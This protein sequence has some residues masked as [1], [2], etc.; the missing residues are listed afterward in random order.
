L[1]CLYFTDPSFSALAETYS[2]III[3]Q[4]VAACKPR[5][6]LGGGLDLGVVVVS[7]PVL[8]VPNV[9]G[10]CCGV[11]RHAVFGATSR[12]GPNKWLTAPTPMARVAPLDGGA[13]HQHLCGPLNGGLGGRFAPTQTPTLT[14]RPHAPQ[15][16]RSVPG[17]RD[18][19]AAIR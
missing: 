14:S 6:G 12:H 2:R 13:T 11:A 15:P 19:Q 18:H 4:L 3:R 17:T 1:T 16:Y 8:G 7:G 10:P 5:G 9:F